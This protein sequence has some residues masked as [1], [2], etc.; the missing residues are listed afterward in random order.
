MHS[1]CVSV[2]GLLLAL[3]VLAQGPSTWLV[4]T[5]PV[6][7]PFMG[8]TQNNEVFGFDADLI[9]AIGIGSN[10]KIAFRFEDADKIPKALESR[11]YDIG[12]GALNPVQVEEVYVKR[13]PY[14]KYGYVF[15]HLGHLKPVK[16]LVEINKKSFG[17]VESEQADEVIKDLKKKILMADLRQYKSNSE[18]ISSLDKGEVP[19]ILIEE[20][21]A[22]ELTYKNPGKYHLSNFKLGQFFIYILV[23]KGQ[24][25]MADTIIKSLAHLKK[26][27]ELNMI[28]K[29]WFGTDMI[30]DYIY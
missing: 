30:H 7:P 3:N 16:E 25:R 1:L 15:V 11:R 10:R 19:Y 27:G 23:G 24:D 6:S 28:F 9:R 18:L 17:Y 13:I 14:L 4:V 22:L 12:I 21:F 26:S 20:P 5:D 2:F 29:R 8:K